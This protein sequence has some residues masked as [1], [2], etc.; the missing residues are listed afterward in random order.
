MINIG[1]HL[2]TAFDKID[3]MFLF[4]ILPERIGLQSVVLL[5]I[6]K[7]FFKIS[8]ESFATSNH[9]FYVFLVMLKLR[10]VCHNGWFLVLYFVLLNAVFRR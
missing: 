9:K 6:E 10:R 1:L 5:F 3:H 7:T 8:F 2:S 4:E